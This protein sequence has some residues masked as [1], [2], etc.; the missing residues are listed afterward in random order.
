MSLNIGITE[1]FWSLPVILKGTFFTKRRIKYKIIDTNTK[2]T[3]IDLIKE[4]KVTIE[5]VAQELMCNKR[6]I[7]NWIK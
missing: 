6:N 2:K 4:G 1:D 5:S 3:Y 7:R